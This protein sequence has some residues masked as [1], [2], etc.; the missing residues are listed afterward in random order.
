[1]DI[2]KLREKLDA[3]RGQWAMI[4]E[5]AGVHTKTLERIRMVDD[6]M[7][8]LRNFEAIKRALDAVPARTKE[9]A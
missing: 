6:Y 1:M 5:V 3:R 7:P 2:K 4:A 8:T 9:E